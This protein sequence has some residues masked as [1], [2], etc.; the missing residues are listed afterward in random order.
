[1]VTYKKSRTEEE[2]QAIIDLQAQNLSRNIS[3]EEADKEG[4]VTL[5][6]TLPILKAMNHPYPHS[7]AMNGNELVGY[8]LVSELH[9]FSHFPEMKPALDIMNEVVYKSAKL[10]R[11]NFFFM[12]QICVAK[13]NRGQGVLKGLYEHQ[14]EHLSSIF[15]YNVTIISSKNQRSLRAHLKVGF[16]LI[17]SVPLPQGYN[18]EIVLWDW[19]Q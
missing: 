17:K 6:H 2:L 9:H 4:F 13:D 19:N 3:Q 5:S 10:E 7:I 14:R 15:D 11:S 16:Q 18:W 1:M 12:G 8:A